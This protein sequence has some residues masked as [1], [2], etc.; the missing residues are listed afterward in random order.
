MSNQ[1]RFCFDV[2]GDV[3]WIKQSKL[4][5]PDALPKV[6]E[7][8]FVFVHP[9]PELVFFFGNSR[10]LFP[11]RKTEPHNRWQPLRL[12][13]SRSRMLLPQPCW[14]MPGLFGKARGLDMILDP[15][16]GV[17]KGRSIF[18]ILKVGAWHTSVPW[19]LIGCPSDQIVITFHVNMTNINT[20]DGSEDLRAVSKRFR[21]CFRNDKKLEKDPTGS[22]ITGR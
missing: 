5:L 17:N 20:R 13:S 3:H 22:K 10:R 21:S 12:P 1:V 15:L 11:L 8:F 18:K 19:L 16:V 14:I 7:P 9:T 6:G 4:N 2:P